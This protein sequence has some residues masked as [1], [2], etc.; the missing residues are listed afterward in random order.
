MKKF[1]FFSLLAFTL[2][3][4]S[5]GGDDD[6][7]IGPAFCTE[8]AFNQAVADAVAELNNAAQIYAADPTTANCEVYRSAASDYL[9]EVR[10]FENCATISERQEFRDSLDE[11]Q[12]SVDM[13]IC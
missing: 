2:L 1:L 8:Q 9:D 12:E 13:I 6:G 11:A 3:S 4:T 7:N 10:R 5:C